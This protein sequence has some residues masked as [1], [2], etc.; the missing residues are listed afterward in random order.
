MNPKLILLACLLS[1][2]ANQTYQPQPVQAESIAAAFD[3]RDLNSAD[4]QRYMQAHGYPADAFPIRQWGTRELT[5]AAFFFDPQLAVARAQWRASQAEEITAGQ[6]PNPTV[7]G[8]AEHHSRAHDVSPWTI[9]FGLDIPIETGNKR[10]I[11][12]DRAASQSEAARIDIGQQAWQVRDKVQRSL[13][14]YRA[15]LLQTALLQR[16]IDLDNAIVQ[17]LEKRLEAGMVSNTELAVARTQLLKAQQALAANANRLSEL[18]AGI[19]AAVGVPTQSLDNARIDTDPPAPIAADQLPS[20]DVQRA[21]LLNRLDIR[22]GLARYAAAESALRLEIARQRPDIVL[23]P[24][25]SFDQGDNRWSLGLSLLLAFLNKNEGPIAE[26]T[27]QRTLE[28][29]RFEALQIKVITEQQQALAQY[30]GRLAELEQ[31]EKLLTSQRQRLAQ[32]ER[33]FESGYIDRMEWTTIQ[34]ENLAAEQGR[35]NAAIET[36]KALAALENALQYPLDGSAPLPSPE[37]NPEDPQ[38]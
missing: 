4:L 2:C 16:E 8:S 15:A 5:L 18:R 10:Q 31:A 25:Y 32:S 24:A 34:L 30:R 37:S 27:A 29:K 6:K 36:Q 7:S 26:A 17:M 3:R 20:A 35:L 21:A 14:D 1:A 12:Q 22:S 38:S 23:S 11:K 13:N 33:Q 28:A 9:T 19:A